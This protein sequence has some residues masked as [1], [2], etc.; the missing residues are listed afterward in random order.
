MRVIDVEAPEE[1]NDDIAR[2]DETLYDSMSEDKTVQVNSRVP[3]S[4]LNFQ[5]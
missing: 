2:D 1:L 4:H 3:Y 5:D